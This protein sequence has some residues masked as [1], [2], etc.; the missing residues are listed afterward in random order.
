MKI[1]R[2][3]D[4]KAWQAGREMTRLVY[5]VT[6]K[7]SFAKDFRLRDQIRDAAGSVMHNVAE[8]FDSGSDGDFIRFL[9]YSR[10]S[11]SETQSELYVALDQGYVAQEEFAAIYDKATEAKKLANAFIAYLDKSR[12]GEQSSK[13][14]IARAGERVVPADESAPSVQPDS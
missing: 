13:P 11:A 1:Q 6:S 4:V 2:F 10:R 7:G 3:G 8:G 9:G 14:G 5:T 12:R